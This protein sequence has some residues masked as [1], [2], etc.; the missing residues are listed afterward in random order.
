MTP[1]APAHHLL[2]YLFV[3]YIPMSEFNLEHY[4]LEEVR[5]RVLEQDPH[6]AE[7]HQA[8]REVMV[9]VLPFVRE[10]SKYQYS[11]L[12][13]R[14]LEP[15]R[16]I[17]FRVPWIDDQGNYRVNR[18]YRVQFNSAL[19]PYKGG[20]RFH[21]S[22]NLS[23][24]KFLAF[25]QTFKNSLTGLPLG[26]GKGGSDFNPKGK[27]EGEIMRFCQSFMSELFKHVSG[28]RDVPAG[29]IGVG[30]REVGYMFG[31]YKRL[32]TTFSGVLTGKG[33]SYGGS[34]VRTQATGF[35][36]LYFVKEML[37]EIDESIENKTV[38]ISGSG[39]VAQYAC[40]KAIEF[41]AKVVSLSDSDGY[42]LDEEGIDAE[43]FAFI[44]KLKNGQNG[45][46]KEYAQKFNCEYREGK[47]WGIPCDLALP[48][49]TQNEICGDEAQKLA[50]NGVICVAEGANMPCTDAAVEVFQ[51]AKI[52]YAPGKASNA[53]GV[54]VS[55]LEMSQNAMHSCWDFE[56]VDQR[57]VEI[58]NKIHTKCV[59]YGKTNGH[60]NYVKGANIAGFIR[61]A[62][63]MIAQ[64]HV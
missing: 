56:D 44:K 9:S 24:I 16:M 5:D 1:S 30:E 47:P 42:V 37:K 18:G 21:P 23:I 31:Q 46:M 55:G 49:A 39:N 22:V 3:N 51:K 35:G 28:T 43:K 52:L 29:D 58:M 41:G 63:A 40:Q 62:D 14:M 10:H 20:L 60:V 54:A 34:E 32:T 53:G 2:L 38:V 11:G 59:R 57:L 61:L 27:S 19:G 17:M 6:E 13:E 7:F 4:T 15:E 12:I 50:D 45:R 26:G 48:C 64:G 36:L 33:L 8:V 25:E